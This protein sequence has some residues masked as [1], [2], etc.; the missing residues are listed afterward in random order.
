VSV[1]LEP[2]AS[3]N[4]TKSDIALKT[5]AVLTCLDKVPPADAFARRMPARRNRFTR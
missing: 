5:A 1:F 4:N 3:F 2:P